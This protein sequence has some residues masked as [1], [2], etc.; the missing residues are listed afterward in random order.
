VLKHNSPDKS[1]LLTYTSLN[2][3]NFNSYPGGPLFNPVG[4]ARDIENAHE[5]KLKEIKN[6][7]L[8]FS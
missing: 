7:I 2:F 6:G 5:E 8:T 3:A 1:L 4:L